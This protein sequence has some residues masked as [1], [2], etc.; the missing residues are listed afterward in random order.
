MADMNGRSGCS[1][2]ARI[3]LLAI[4]ALA[5][6]LLIFMFQTGIDRP[7]PAMR[8]PVSGAPPQGGR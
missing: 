4:V 2:R 7:N 8:S 6:G 5:L 1:F 3:L